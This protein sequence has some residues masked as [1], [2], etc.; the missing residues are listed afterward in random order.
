MTRYSRDAEALAVSLLEVFPPGI[1]SAALDDKEFCDELGLTI[2]S[3]IRFDQA[4]VGFRRSAFF[5]AVREALTAR[6]PSVIVFDLEGQEW[7]LGAGDE[8]GRLLMNRGTQT[9]VPPD[10]S[11]LSSDVAQRLAWFEREA[12][13][14]KVNDDHITRWRRILT[15]RRVEDEEVTSLLDEFKQTPIYVEASIARDFEK[16]ITD[17]N[18]LIPKELRYYERLVGKCVVGLG[19]NEYFER[20]AFPNVRQAVQQEPAQGLKASFLLSAHQLGSRAIPLREISHSTVV[21]VYGWIVDAGDRVSQIG[22]IE[23]ALFHLDAFP[24]LEP[25]IEKLITIILSD[26][27]DDK[28]GRLLLLS[29]LIVMVDGELS[30]NGRC[31]DH[32]PYWRRLA[33]IAHAAVVERAILAAG[34]LPEGFLKWVEESWAGVHYLQS[35]ADLRQEPRWLPEFISPDVLH[36]E[37]ISRVAS[38]AHVNEGKIKGEQLEHLLNGEDD[39][40]RA[41]LAFPFSF[42]PGPLEGNIEPLHDVPHDIQARVQDSLQEK[43]LTVESFVV[44]VNASLI[45]RVDPSLALAAAEGLRRTK[46]RLRQVQSSEEAFFLLVGLARIAC[47]TRNIELAKE[48]ATLLRV[49]RARN[50]M[51]LSL[52][53]ATRVALVAAAAHTDVQSWSQ[54]VGHCMSEFSFQEVDADTALW[55]RESLRRLKDIQPELCTT[56]AVADASISSFLAS[57]GARTA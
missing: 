26:V 1:R 13:K 43:E 7:R 39:S 28:D 44:L 25:Y 29:N 24:E 32:P 37:L 35:M 42:L 38:A 15:D 45:F 30:R 52:Q 36:A 22:A 47:V 23:C 33:A 12:V 2:D 57:I 6:E 50:D 53:N 46:Y 56:L 27:P 41:K 3:T 19:L 5:Q 54:F 51:K 8:K 17:A 31:R 21:E 20:V 9:I 48:V 16:F 10:F 40:I 18:K 49:V 55:L 34:K 14:Y 11:L 4:G